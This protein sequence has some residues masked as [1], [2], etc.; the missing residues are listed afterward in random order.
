MK[1]SP[2]CSRDNGREV[3]FTA[4]AQDSKLRFTAPRELLDD[5]LGDDAKEA[6]RKAWVTENKDIILAQRGATVTQP[7]FDRVRIEEIA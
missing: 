5:V 6:T 4:K 1:T 7:P 3:Y 2:L